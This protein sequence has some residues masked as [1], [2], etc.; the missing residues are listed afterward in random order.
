MGSSGFNDSYWLR[1]HLQAFPSPTG[2]R[3]SVLVTGRNRSSGMISKDSRWSSGGPASQ[4]QEGDCFGQQ[5][6]LQV[7]EANEAPEEV[8]LQ[9]DSLFTTLTLGGEEEK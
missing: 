6:S 9:H 4:F 5:R 3:H 2:F 7:F 1:P 8:F